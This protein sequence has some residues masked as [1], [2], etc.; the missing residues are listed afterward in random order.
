M[1]DDKTEFHSQESVLWVCDFY[2][3]SFFLFYIYVWPMVVLK[4]KRRHIHPYQSL[5]TSITKPAPVTAV[6]NFLISIQNV[7]RA[8]LP[9]PLKKLERNPGRAYLDF[10]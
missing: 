4:Y 2:G 6:Y 5:A 3:K 7:T 10:W 1:G 8:N 9:L